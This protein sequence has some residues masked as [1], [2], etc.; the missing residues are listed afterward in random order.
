MNSLLIS[1][2]RGVAYWDSS[3]WS[4]ERVKLGAFWTISYWSVANSGLGEPLSIEAALEV[5]GTSPLS[6]RACAYSLD[7]MVFRKAIAVSLCL[8]R[9]L[10]DQ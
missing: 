7:A 4:H 9:A 1:V 10:M 5:V 2:S 6:T 8:V 3:A